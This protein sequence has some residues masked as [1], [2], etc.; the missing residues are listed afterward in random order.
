MKKKLILVFAA[1]FAGIASLEAKE[2]LDYVNMFVGA[3]GYHVTAYGGTT[4]AVGSPFAMTQWCAATRENKIS[5]TVYHYDDKTCIGFIASHQPTIWMGDYGFFTLMPQL[6]EPKLGVEERGVKIDHN[7]QVATPYYYKLAYDVPEGG[8][9]T[10]EITATSRAGFLKIHYPQNAKA[11]PV[12]YI[13]AARAEQK[14]FGGEIAVFPDKREIRLF[15]Q[16]RHDAHL[17][18]ELKNLK[19]YYVLK[20]DK[21]FKLLGVYNNGQKK[22]YV[23]S[24]SGGYDVSCA[25]EFAED[26]GTVQVKSGSSFISYEQAADNLEREIGDN[27]FDKTKA[28]VKAQW[29]NYFDKIEI[30]GA[31]ELDKRIFF[32]ALF[33]TLQLPREFSEYGRY[34]SAFDD[35]IHEGVSY[36]AYS[37]WDTFRAQHPFLQIIAP[38]RVSPMVQAL[39]QMYKESGWLPKWPNPSFTNIMIGTH[40]DA[41]IADAYV[42]GFRDFDVKTA[43]EAI[44]KDATVPP[45]NDEK[46]RWVDRGLWKEGF[47]Y[48]A[49]SGLTSYLKRGYVTSDYTNESVSRTLEFAL[50]DYCVAQMA[51]ALGKD[52]DYKTFMRHSENYRNLFN[53]ETNF[54]HA[55]KADGKW[56]PNRHEGMTESKNW[57]YRFCVMQNL[58]GLIELMGGEQNFVKNLDEVFEKGH[59]AH[60]NEPSHHYVYLYNYCDRLDIAQKRIP[61]IMFDNY[62]DEPKG[63]TGN[64]DCGQMSAW[65][66]FTAMGF[67]PMCPASG[68]YVLGLPRFKRIKVALPNGKFIEVKAEKAGVAKTMQNI[69]FNGKKV[70]KPYTIKV[71]DVLNGCLLEFKE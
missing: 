6:G 56:H 66:I 33:R 14:P 50:D 67:Y 32:T 3:S 68:E 41:V 2:N 21:P 54:F 51:K 48:E 49:R 53:K 47:G 8:E 18:P 63:L 31:S 65:Y 24:V 71:K 40:A 16:E 43:Y 61:K 10:T 62:K 52:D 1:F 57:Q 28:I 25:I 4:P 64:D 23:N 19:G 36:N 37:L 7:R 42:N 17:G 13:Q 55:K 20:F 46:S 45:S 58:Y 9:I 12:M 38:E 44:R 11:K 22:D 59:Y 35:K 60:N 15:N 70:E 29:Q 27:S 34:Y 26:V 69:Y 5:R 39:V 30:E